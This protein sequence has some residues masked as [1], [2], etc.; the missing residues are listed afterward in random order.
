MPDVTATLTAHHR[1]CDELFLAAEAAAADGKWPECEAKFGAYR[2]EIERHIEFEEQVLFPAFEQGTG[3]T[4]GPTT[5]MREEHA[6]IRDLNDRMAAAAARRDAGE[7]LAASETFLVLMQQH[8]LKEEGVLY[9]ECDALLGPQG[10]A[11]GEGLRAF[12]VPV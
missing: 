7:F 5:V 6:Q 3:M 1:A 11:I 8:N 9:P 4:Q 10:G 2:A 12:E